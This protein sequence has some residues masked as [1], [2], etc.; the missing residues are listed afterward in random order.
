MD[1]REARDLLKNG[2]RGEN[3]MR[4]LSD[5]VVTKKKVG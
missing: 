1:E 3:V 5:F 2:I 4:S